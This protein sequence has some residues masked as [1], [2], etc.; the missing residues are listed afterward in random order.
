MMTGKPVKQYEWDRKRAIWEGAALASIFTLVNAY[1]NPPMTYSW[2][3]NAGAISGS[4]TVYFIISALFCFVV[5]RYMGRPPLKRRKSLS[6][7]LQ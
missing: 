3:G 4:W 5:N 2:A 7:P 1:H 6:R